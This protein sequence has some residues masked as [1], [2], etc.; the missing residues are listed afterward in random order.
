MRKKNKQDED[1][2]FIYEKREEEKKKGEINFIFFLNFFF[3]KTQHEE[4][5]K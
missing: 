5:E 2:F 3:G 1:Q 4:K